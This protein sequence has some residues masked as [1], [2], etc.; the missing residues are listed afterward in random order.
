MLS[1][2]LSLLQHHCQVALIQNAGQMIHMLPSWHVQLSPPCLTSSMSRD[3]KRVPYQAN[4]NLQ[5]SIRTFASSPPPIHHSE[6]QWWVRSRH[7]F[8]LTSIPQGL[9]GPPLQWT[10]FAESILWYT[11]WLASLFCKGSS[12]QDRTLVTF[13]TRDD[14]AFS[15]GRGFLSRESQESSIRKCARPTIQTQKRWAC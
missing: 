4:E 8:V 9:L 1:S 11:W 3:N 5:D 13:M 12:Q 15:R 10:T 7:S 2:S 6:N 14:S